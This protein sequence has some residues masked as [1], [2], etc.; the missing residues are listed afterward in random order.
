[1]WLCTF[2]ACVADR[3][4]CPRDCTGCVHAPAPFLRPAR[5]ME[6]WYKL[7]RNI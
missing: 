5:C 2:G 4:H 7:T 6:Y 3:T 1:M